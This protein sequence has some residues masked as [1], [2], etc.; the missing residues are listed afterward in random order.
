MFCTRGRMQ[1][2]QFPCALGNVC[3]S[4]EIDLPVRQV[5]ILKMTV[6]ASMLT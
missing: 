6:L 3:Y 1:R 4:E 2:P 5:W